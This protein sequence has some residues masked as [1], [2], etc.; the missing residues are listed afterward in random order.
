M[1]DYIFITEFA[2][3]RQLEMEEAT[4][5]L[6]QFASG[7]ASPDF[8]RGAMQMLRAVINLPVKAAKTKEAMERATLLRDKAMGEFEAK[9]MRKFMM[10]DYEVHTD[11]PT[12]GST[13]RKE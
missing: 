2:E 3:Y 12:A 13:A 1:E 7:T 8:L 9:M 4:T 10:N 6:R 5:I 11:K